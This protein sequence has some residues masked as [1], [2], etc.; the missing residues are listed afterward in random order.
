M[1]LRCDN[2]KKMMDIVVGD[3]RV[4]ERVGI[5]R[6]KHARQSSNPCAEE[7]ESPRGLLPSLR[8]SVRMS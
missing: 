8:D 5:D 3:G 6:E 7:D 4:S 2:V 1:L